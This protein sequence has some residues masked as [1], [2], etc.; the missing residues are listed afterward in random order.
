MLYSSKKKLIVLKEIHTKLLENDFSLQPDVVDIYITRLEGEVT[1]TQLEN[2]LNDLNKIP[3]LEILGDTKYGRGF[4]IRV[5]KEFKEFD[6]YLT[7]LI[8]EAKNASLK[9][10]TK[11][12]PDFS[13]SEVVKFGKIFDVYIDP[14]M[15]KYYGANAATN[16]GICTKFKSQIQP[17]C[18]V[19]LAAIKYQDEKYKKLNSSY[20]YVDISYAELQE[21]IIEW[22]H[23]GIKKKSLSSSHKKSMRTIRGNIGK[24][25]SF[26]SKELKFIENDKGEAI[27]RFYF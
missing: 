3:I 12:E 25:I 21:K 13:R 9:L 19:R 2:I 17:F 15:V 14:H 20:R 24:K 4:Q 23:K 5:L 10:V 11:K 6:K 27:L 7:E 26:T 18:A 1:L 16:E 8:N 22:K